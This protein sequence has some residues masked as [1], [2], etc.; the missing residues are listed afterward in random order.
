MDSGLI[1]TIKNNWAEAKAARWAVLSLVVIAAGLGFGFAKFV[2]AGSLSAKD[3]T[4][5]TLKAQIDVLRMGAQRPENVGTPSK[6]QQGECEGLLPAP[7]LRC[8][9]RHWEE[10]HPA[11]P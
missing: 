2:D 10:E 3:A 8:E 6:A 1:E 7:T 11:P 4:I 9:M 5:E